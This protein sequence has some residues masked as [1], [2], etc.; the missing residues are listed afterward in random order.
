MSDTS[1]IRPLIPDR[2]ATQAATLE[3]FAVAASGPGVALRSLSAHLEKLAVEG[4][5]RAAADCSVWKRS[6]ASARF[7]VRPSK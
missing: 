5:A 2:Q 6:T 7:R 4:R 1:A 3:G